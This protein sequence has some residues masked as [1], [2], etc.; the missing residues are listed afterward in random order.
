LISEV[1]QSRYGVLPDGMIFI[2]IFTNTCK[3][4]PIIS[5]SVNALRQ[6]LNQWSPGPWWSASFA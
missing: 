4:V 3:L 6:F 1:K 2:P 5:M